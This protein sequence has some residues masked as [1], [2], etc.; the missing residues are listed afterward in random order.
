MIKKDCK[1]IDIYSI[2]YV[3]VK[4]NANCSNINSVNPLY[5]MINEIIGHF[6]EK[7][8]NKYL[9]LDDVDENKEVS[10][11]YE[12]VWEGVK[13]EI[14]TINGGEKVEYENDFKKI[15]FE[16]NDNLPM[17]EPIKLRLLTIN[18]RSAFS[19]DGKL[20]PQLFL[21]DALYE[22]V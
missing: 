22:L 6:E 12:E 18:I 15:M 14:E 20:Y 2:G 21:D 17:N 11:I 4:K 7:S 9:V 13:E 19:E 16:P 5:L 8:E 1:E 10:K 3:T